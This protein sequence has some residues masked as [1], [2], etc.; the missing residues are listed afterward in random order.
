[1]TVREGNL[2]A[3]T[4][5][6]LDWRNAEFYD[7]AALEREMER[8]FDICH[9]CRRCVSLCQSFPT[10]FDLVDNSKTMEVDGVAKSDYGKVVDQCYLCDLCYMT[11]CPYVPPHPWNVDFP[12][13]MLRAKAVGFR[14]GKSRWRD[15]LLTSTDRVGRLATIPVVVRMVN[16]VNTMPSARKAMDKA[17]GVAEGAAL[18]PYNAARFRE[19]AQTS[20]AW[21]VRAGARTPGKV[22]VFATCYVN[23]NEPGIGHDLVRVLE[24][25]EIPYRL[26]E[27]EACCGMPKL[28][29]GDL[30]S[31]EALKDINI[32]PL[33]A[34]ARAG[35]AILTAVPSCTLMWKHELP[36]IF[37]DDPDV[38]AVADTMFD[39][40]EYLVLRDKDGLLRKDFTTPLGKVSYHIPCHSRVQNVGQK[41]REVLEWIPGTV[42]NTVERCAGHDG[43]YGVKREF[44]A[45]SMKIG[46]PV[47]RRMAETEPDFVCSDCPIAGRRIAQGMAAAGSA[48]GARKEHP[49]T[50]LRMAYGL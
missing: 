28:E 46:Q 43:T 2:Q 29:L 16:K 40:F 37:P 24:H 41:T 32:G 36:L 14:Q 44:F 20:V 30:E 8:I 39:P 22:A 19:T 5:H 35:Y 17:L 11:K 42:V 45:N 13:L 9:G 48:H 26:V 27:K 34:L 49:L 1:M 23:Y 7:E 25:N 33:A 21:P 15:R 18:P 4:R 50:L 12:H 3:P 10:L 47:F 31:V 38:Q 6:P